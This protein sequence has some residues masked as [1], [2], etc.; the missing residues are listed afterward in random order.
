MRLSKRLIYGSMFRKFVLAGA[1]LIIWANPSKASE[2]ANNPGDR[3]FVIASSNNF[4]PVNQL[5]E[6]GELTG[7]GK[8][9][10]NAVIKAVGGTYS[11]IHSAIWKDVLA[12]LA[13]GRADFIHDTGYSI[14]RTAFLDYSAP[15]LVMPEEIFVRA[16]RFNIASQ[17]SLKTAKVACVNKHISHL[18]L[19]NVLGI[20]CRVVA[21][22]V[23]GLYS[24]INGD[25]DA[26]VFP[27][28]VLLHIAQ[29]LNVINRIKV[30][31]EPLRE[32]TWHMTVRKGDQE[33]L[34]LLNQG[35]AA[36]KASGQYDEIYEY[37]F[38][39]VRTLG[40]SQKEISIIIAI[41]VALSLSVAVL[42]GL[43]IRTIQLNK[44]RKNLTISLEELERTEQALRQSEERFSLAMRGANDGLWDWNL[45]TDEIYY[46]PRWA[47]MLGYEQDEIEPSLDSW[48]R[49]VDPRDKDRILKIVGD[50]IEG[51][52]DNGDSEFR[53]RHKNGTWV[54]ILSR[55][56]LVDDNGEAVRL[57]GTH[58]DISERKKF[59][60]ELIQYRDHLEELVSERTSEVQEKAAQLE[61]A[62]ESEKKYSAMQQQFVSL[63]SH[64]FRTPLT[65]IDGAAQRLMRTS[66]NIVPAELFERAKKI[67]D[68]VERMVGLIDTTLYASRLDAGKIEVKYASVNLKEM[69]ESVCEHQAEL[70][71]FH[72][73][74]LDL[75]D[76]P[77]SIE[78]DSGL[79]EHVFTNL[80]SNA[81][82]YALDAPLIEVTGRTD[83]SWV[84]IS[85]R[86]FGCGIPEKELPR[87]FER[88]FR[89]ETARG[90]GGSGIGLN[91]SKSF[92]EIHNGELAIS[93]IE[94]KETTVTVRLPIA[95]PIESAAE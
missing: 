21:T 26:F 72:E 20:E 74:Q 68:A 49:L 69:I 66:K 70:S 50:Y 23:E 85:V 57:V 10:S 3:H 2:T 90:F 82:K 24:L 93:S 76:I 12:A 36:I 94:G 40:Y 79:L 83:A 33:M 14:E 64:E 60:E 63:V 48:A 28:Q 92:V 32:L 17:M 86:D 16:D 78:A 73:I 52:T 89:A 51:V 46:S 42:L 9:I 34:Q 55:A 95:G 5:D 41:L 22:P 4:P 1:I 35:I 39:R 6:D 30:V 25:V 27:R 47:S 38:G 65:I 13:E 7:F 11:R 56:F 31:G 81:V 19:V 77:D 87:I 58:V 53:M 91:I 44:K 18:Y 8:D 61:Q 80:L 84:T 45:K 54:T 29:R 62:L 75:D 59:E 67:R 71:P 43:L 37:W 15:I 88:Y